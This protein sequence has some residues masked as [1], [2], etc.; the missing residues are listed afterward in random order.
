MKFEFQKD[1]SNATINPLYIEKAKINIK[2][3]EKSLFSLLGVSYVKCLGFR[4]VLFL[5]IP[6][7]FIWLLNYN[8]IY[9]YIWLFYV[10]M[11]QAALINTIILDEK[12]LLP[13]IFYQMK[14][15]MRY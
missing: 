15:T 5:I 3:N 4:I 11:A 12:S 6:I 7:C 13:I 8:I 10:V 2:T 14:M 1:A 9:S